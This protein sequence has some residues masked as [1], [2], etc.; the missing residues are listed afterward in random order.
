MITAQLPSFIYGTAG[1]GT[2]TTELVKEAIGAGFTAI[3]AANQPKHYSESYL[4]L[5][6]KWELYR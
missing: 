5:P 4:N 2:K 1:K 6:C 3:D